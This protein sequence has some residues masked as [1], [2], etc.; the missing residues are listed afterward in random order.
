MYYLY[1]KMHNDWRGRRY[2]RK[3]SLRSSIIY[4]HVSINFILGWSFLYFVLHEHNI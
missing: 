2:V 4:V 3:V 1:M